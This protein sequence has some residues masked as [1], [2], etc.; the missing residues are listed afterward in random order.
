MRFLLLFAFALLS[1]GSAE[2]GVL[3]IA[4]AANLNQVL[5]ALLSAY[6]ISHP[7]TMLIVS[8]GSS[9]SLSQ[10][11]ARGAP[12]HVFLSASPRYIEYLDSKGLLSDSKPFAEGRLVLYLKSAFA[13]RPPEVHRLL[14]SDVKRIVIANPEF[15]PY[16]VAAISCMKH[17]GIYQH[18]AGKLIYA[19]NVSQAAQMTLVAADA[20][21]LALPLASSEA[22]Q[23]RGTFTVLGDDCHQPLLQIAAITKEG[24]SQSARA[25]L[26]FLG[27]KTAIRIISNYGYGIP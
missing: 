17:S 5:P 11:I 21:F 6:H 14:K 2:G 18:V 19:D 24:Q 23:K 10:Q 26:A 20:A 12:Y 8:Y 4:A 3:R 27:S 15:A 22:L 1:F 25:F 13:E 7:K 9:G 16:G